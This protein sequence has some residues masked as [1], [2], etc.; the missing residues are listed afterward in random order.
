VFA[1]GRLAVTR[2][3]L[4]PCVGINSNGGKLQV[5]G[6]QH[7]LQ[8]H[9]MTYQIVPNLVFQFIIAYKENDRIY[10]WAQGFSQRPV[11]LSNDLP[12]VAQFWPVTESTLFSSFQNNAAGVWLTR[13][14]MPVTDLLVTRSCNKFASSKVR[15]SSDWCSSS[16]WFTTRKRWR[17]YVKVYCSDTLKDDGSY[18]LYPTTRI[19]VWPKISMIPLLGFTPLVI[20]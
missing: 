8:W 6:T 5:F 3:W 14:K 20:A 4:H 1:S 19:L 18:D 17:R 7:S 16:D 11:S 2:S 10:E 13:C 9:R 15:S 12:V